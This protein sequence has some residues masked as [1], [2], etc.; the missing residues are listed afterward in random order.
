MFLTFCVQIVTE[1]YDCDGNHSNDAGFSVFNICS[2]LCQRYQIRHNSQTPKSVK[3]LGAQGFLGFHVIEGNRGKSL[4]ATQ[5]A[6]LY[7]GNL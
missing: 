2:N 5:A 6:G 7:E 3:S 1:T 4:I